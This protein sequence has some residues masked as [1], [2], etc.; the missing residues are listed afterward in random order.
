MS[1]KPRVQLSR[2]DMLKTFTVLYN[3]QTAK[4]L[5]P[6][7]TL[8]DQEMNGKQPLMHLLSKYIIRPNAF[9]RDP[10]YIPP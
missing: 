1:N 3:D 5:E 7:P 6:I 4:T 8:M 9:D 10:F 2:D